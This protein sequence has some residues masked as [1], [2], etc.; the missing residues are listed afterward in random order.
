MVLNLSGAKILAEITARR[1]ELKKVARAQHC[2]SLTPH[3]SICFFIAFEFCPILTCVLLAYVFL[4]RLQVP[5]YGSLDLSIVC[6]I[7]PNIFLAY[8]FP[9]CMSHSSFCLSSLCLSSLCLSSLCLSSSCL[10]SLRLSS[11]CLPAHVKYFLPIQL[12]NYQQKKTGKCSKKIYFT[13]EKINIEI[14]ELPSKIT[15]VATCFN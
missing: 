2:S 13:F 12:P 4:H 14:C 7:L 6:P 8:V 15:G 11:L 9:E 1:R 5:F 3:H 10:S